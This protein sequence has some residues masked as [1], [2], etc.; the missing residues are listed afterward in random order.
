MECIEMDFRT[1][2]EIWFA[3]NTYDL[4]F[5]YQK[6]LFTLIQHAN[7]KFGEQNITEIKPFDIAELVKELAIKN[8]NTGKPTS[9]KTLQTLVM[10]LYRMFDMAIDNDWLI[11]NPAKKRSKFIPKNAP[12]KKVK[13]ISKA[14]QLSILTTSHRCQIAALLMMFTGLRTGELLALEWS[15]VDLVSKRIHVHRHTVKI[16][17][18]QF[19]SEEG[20]KTGKTRFVTIPDNMCTYL[21]NEK[22]KSTSIYVFPKTDGT[23]N[24][25]SSFKSAWNSYINTLNFEDYR[26]NFNGEISKFDPKG[27][28]KN[29]KINPHQLRHTYATLLYISKTDPL[30]ASKL[31]GHSSVQLTLDIY[32]D[33]ETQY[34]TLDISN[35]NSYLSNDL[36]RL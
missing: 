17:S 19:I 26:R 25:P 20:T 15:D 21:A 4:C 9:R 35:F 33:L 30:T 31:L 13:A 3:E 23:M 5:T 11:K 22:K 12:K 7:L 29:I 16:S 27:Y 14:D 10:T 6:S 28:P 32:T 34:K 1:L 24:T 8:P 18:N 36:C 2:S